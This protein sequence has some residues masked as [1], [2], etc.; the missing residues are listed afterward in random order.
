MEG[1]QIVLHVTSPLEKTDCSSSDILTIDSLITLYPMGISIRETSLS[2]EDSMAPVIISAH[3][4]DSVKRD[5][6]DLLT[7]TYSEPISYSTNVDET[8]LSMPFY[9][10]EQNSKSTFSTQVSFI[11]NEL[12]ATQEYFVPWNDSTTFRVST[13]DSIWINTSDAISIVDAN[14]NFQQN[15]TNIRREV[16][17]DYVLTP[18][19]LKMRATLLKDN[20]NGEAIDQLGSI[21]VLAPLL[22]DAGDKFM[23][24]GIVPDPIESFFKLDVIEGRVSIFDV[25]GNQVVSNLPLHFDPESKQLLTIWNGKNEA[26]RSVGSGSYVAIAKVKFTPFEGDPTILVLRSLVGVQK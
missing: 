9:F 24:I 13:G 7:V 11:T 5:S 22:A 18:F 3:V 2:P 16:T 23:I 4:V 21:E 26:N 25:V 15:F 12:G 19:T 10:T 14:G 1:E 8:V 20:S 17:V 6:E